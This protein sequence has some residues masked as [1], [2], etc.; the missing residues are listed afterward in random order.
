MYLVRL[1]YASTVNE[2]FKSADIEKILAFAKDNNA[3]NCVTGMLCFNHKYFLQCLEGSRA[4][5]NETY[6]QISRDNRH[7]DIILLDYQVITYRE[8]SDW[9][10]GYIPTSKLT[11]DITFN[12]SRTNEFNPYELSGESAWQM[13][14]ALRSTVPAL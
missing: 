9:S 3:R 11:N 10:M 4:K 7:K 6:N 8:F 5:V 13:L 1:V 12:F 14:L 2:H